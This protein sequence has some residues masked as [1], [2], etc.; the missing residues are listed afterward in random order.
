MRRSVSNCNKTGL[1]LPELMLIMTLILVITGLMAGVARNYSETLRFGAGKARTLEVA[2]V[3]LQRVA[4]EAMSAVQF[5]APSPAGQV[6]DFE[7][8][9]AAAAIT[10][11]PDLSGGVPVSW[12]PAAA[13]DRIRVTYRHDISGHLN[14]E[15]AGETQVIG[16][17]LTGFEAS[18]NSAESLTL[19]LS[20]QEAKRVRTLSTVVYLPTRFGP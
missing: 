19:I 20:V 6:L 5:F 1:S 13:G 4:S 12:N 14:R 10:R 9:D 18:F 17:G 3:A 15:V 2:Q 8:I 11:L 16:E 7:R